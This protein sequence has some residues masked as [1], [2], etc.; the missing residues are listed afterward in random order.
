MVR[1]SCGLKPVLDGGGGGHSVFARLL[2]NKLKNS[3][4]PMIS[5][6][7]Y[8]S[9]AKSVT[10]ISKNFNLEQIPTISSL[11]MSGHEAPDFVFIPK[12]NS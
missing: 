1:S 6:E 7:L 8:S 11:P 12:N 9:I 10:E 5:S 4:K 3:N 2:I